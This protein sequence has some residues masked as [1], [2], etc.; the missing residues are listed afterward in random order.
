VHTALW[1]ADHFYQVLATSLNSQL[2]KQFPPTLKTK[3]E[4]F[5]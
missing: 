4:K 5:E 3:E 1:G 2:M